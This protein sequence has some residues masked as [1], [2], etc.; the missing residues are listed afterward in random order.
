VIPPGLVMSHGGFLLVSP[1]NLN[2]TPYN[3]CGLVYC[4]TLV[5]SKEHSESLAIIITFVRFPFLSRFERKV[6]CESLLLSHESIIVVTVGYNNSSTL[7]QGFLGQDRHFLTT[8]ACN[9]T[10]R[11]VIGYLSVLN[12]RIGLCSCTRWSNLFDCI[13][14]V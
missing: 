5:Q 8:F 13:I 11:W 3:F 12:V 4:Y 10:C 2:T 9:N 6:I 14:R 7:S 1:A